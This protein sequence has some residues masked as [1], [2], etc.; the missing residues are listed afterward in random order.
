MFEAVRSWPDGETTV[1]RFAETARRYGYDGVV[2]RNLSDRRAEYD[3]D[4]IREGF[5]VDVVDGIEIDADGPSQASGY[6]GNFRTKHT[7]L[8]L[9]GGSPKMNRFA[10]ENERVDVLSRPMAER[11][12]FNHVLAKAAAT[13]G[14]RV[15]FDLSRVLRADGGPRVQAIGDLRKLRELVEHYDVPFVVSATPASHLQLRA[16][17]ELVAVG[18]AIG[19]DAEQIERGLAEWRQLAERNRTRMADDFVA[20]GVKRGRYEADEVDEMNGTG[21]ADGGDRE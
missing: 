13:N 18:E 5:G 10:V 16:P 1:S 7:L 15:E 8:L 21:G 12:D 9:R 6:V 14:V 2:V 11:G 3:P 4:R 19:F 20:P 17:R